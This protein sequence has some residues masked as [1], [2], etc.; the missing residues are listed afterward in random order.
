MICSGLNP[1]LKDP[2]GLDFIPILIG[3]VAGGLGAIVLAIIIGAYR[4]AKTR[5]LKMLSPEE[6]AKLAS[7]Q[8]LALGS[9][10]TSQGSMNP[11]G[12]PAFSVSSSSNKY[13]NGYGPNA[14]NPVYNNNSPV[15]SAG[16]GGSNLTPYQQQYLAQ[17]AALAQGG[18]DHNTHS[19]IAPSMRASQMVARAV[20]AGPSITASATPLVVMFEFIAERD[21]EL[22]AAVGDR[23]LG[24]E[25][26]DGWWLAQNE[27]GIM[28]LIPVSYT[29]VDTNPAPGPSKTVE[30][31]F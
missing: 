27:K 24:I 15:L 19:R 8:S 5:R 13:D 9:P 23:M 7:S 29:A 25:Q 20:S 30:P 6:M 28:G 2:A 11:I 22:T 31:A 10:L 3:A 1:A 4:R 21:D 16:S 12:S 26:Q 18:V 17:Q 14:N